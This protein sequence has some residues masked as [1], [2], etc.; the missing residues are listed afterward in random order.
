VR[1]K[2]EPSV[3][4]KVR[5]SLEQQ[6]KKNEKAGVDTPALDKIRRTLKRKAKRIEKAKTGTVDRAKFVES[7]SLGLSD[8]LGFGKYKSRTLRK[9]LDDD[10]MYLVWILDNNKEIRFNQKVMSELDIFIA[11]DELA[12]EQGEVPYEDWEILDQ[13]D[14][15]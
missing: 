13:Q 10:P 7:I 6:V 14:T 5:K 1:Q 4:D 3:L 12:K 2:T 15:Y 9:I 8:K 11:H